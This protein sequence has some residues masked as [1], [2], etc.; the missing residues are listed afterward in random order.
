MAKGY[1]WKIG[2]KKTAKNVLIMFGAPAVIYVLEHI[3][4]IVPDQCVAVA[5][6]VAGA[7]TYGI[8]NYLENR[9]NK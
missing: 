1:D 6:P 4:D 7:I 9:K 5:V 8:K 2:L 3:T